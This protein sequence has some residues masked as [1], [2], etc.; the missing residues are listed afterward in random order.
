[1]SGTWGMIGGTLV[2]QGGGA[3]PTVLSTVDVSDV[4]T[5]TANATAHTKGAWTEIIASTSGEATLLIV[6]VRA[7]AQNATATA[8]LL[9][10]AVG[11]VGAE[12][13][14]AQNIAVGGASDAGGAHFSIPIP[15]TVAAG[16]RVSA[17]IQSVVTGGKTAIVSIAGVAGA[18]ITSE[19]ALVTIGSSTGTSAGTS[20]GTSWTQITAST[21]A[22]YRYLVVVPSLSTAA[23]SGAGTDLQIASGAASSEVQIGRVFLTTTTTEA[24]YAPAAAPWPM[25]AIIPGVP[26]GTRLSARRATAP[27]DVTILGV[28]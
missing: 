26:A 17:R 16:S 6:A 18:A 2:G 5:V 11:G 13:P 4:I 1:M 10:V 12:V 23:A 3:T 19:S 21:A 8:T 25:F 7:I 15:V 28:L 27:C 9:D 14:I 24:V 20:A 22:A